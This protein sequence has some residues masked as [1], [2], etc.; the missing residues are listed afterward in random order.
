[1]ESPTI[2][3]T[4][5]SVTLKPKLCLKSYKWNHQTKIRIIQRIVIMIMNNICAK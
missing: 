1:V 5:I 2:T 4:P 3:P